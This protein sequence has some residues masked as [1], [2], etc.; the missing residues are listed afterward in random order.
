MSRPSR[1]RRLSRVAGAG[2]GVRRARLIGSA[3]LIAS[4]GLTAGQA[5]PAAA[6]ATGIRLEPI[7]RG[8][9]PIGSLQI[10]KN[11]PF[12][13]GG[14][15]DQGQVI[16]AAES[17]TGGQMLLQ[18][19]GGRL[20]PIVVPGAAA[21]GGQWSKSGHVRA[22]VS[23]NEGGSAV[24][25]ADVVIGGK[26]DVGTFRWE[27]PTGEVQPLALTG[28]AVI[29]NLTFALGGGQT[30]VI[31]TAGDVAFVAKVRSAAGTT[32]DGVF[33]RGRD[34]SAQPLAAPEQELP[35]GSSLLHAWLPSLDDAGR[36][37]MVARLRG[38][39]LDSLCIWEQGTLN[40]VPPLG[41]EA[42]GARHLA[43]FT[44]VWLNTAN[45]NMLVSAHVHG[46]SGASNSLFLITGSKTIP[47][48]VTGQ[49]MPGGHRFQTVQPQNPRTL[50]VSLASGVSAT[51]ARGQH[52][53]LAQL[54]G[55]GTAAYLMDADGTLSLLLKSGMTTPLGKIHA[56][57]LGSGRSQGIG[58]NNKGQVAL[59]VQLTGVPNLLV[60]VTLQ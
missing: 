31:N 34:G 29:Q 23:M 44:G 52:A 20:I 43:G 48:A 56:V 26:P 40:L 28:M 11:S 6:P 2:R 22:P 57:G 36:V 21:P 15:N 12:F 3:A 10:K 58:L 17:A 46:L 27:A 33:F 18:S 14:L 4:L 53:I 8:G 16:F 55:G 24:F 1:R 47:V 25:A 37:A 42:V 13:V 5:H 60:L 38:I 32:R 7:A 19:S 35:D 39:P 51:N 41:R 49:P 45:R 9:E 50:E 59:T 30:P 54:E